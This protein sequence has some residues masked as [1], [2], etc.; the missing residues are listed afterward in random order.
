V[1]E[2]FAQADYPLMY[3]GPKEF[4]AYMKTDF[5]SNKQILSKLQ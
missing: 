5:E 3:K 2:K 1:K 4:T